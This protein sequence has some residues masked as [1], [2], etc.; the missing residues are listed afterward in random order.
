VNRMQK[1]K[2]KCGFRV[3]P[4]P[5]LDLCSREIYLDE[6][7]LK[8]RK[9]PSCNFSNNYLV[10]WHQDGPSTVV[11]YNGTSLMGLRLFLKEGGK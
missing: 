9:G 4:D 11:D 7:F 5:W 8:A 6:L 1:L 10:A 2:V 3:C